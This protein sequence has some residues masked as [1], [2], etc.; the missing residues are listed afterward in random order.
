[1][2][3]SL[4]TLT[5]GNAA[6]ASFPSLKIGGRNATS[7]NI[8]A[9]SFTLAGVG[10][11]LVSDSVVYCDPNAPP[12]TEALGLFGPGL[13]PPPPAGIV[14][15]AEARPVWHWWLIGGAHTRY[16]PGLIYVINTLYR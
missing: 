6:G 2:I 8:T 7:F 15:P 4:G 5:K 14:R 11:L 9:A 12:S 16:A 13:A 1:M 3:A 10:R